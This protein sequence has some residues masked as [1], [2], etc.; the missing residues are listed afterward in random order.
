MQ[1]SRLIRIKFSQW[2]RYLLEVLLVIP[3][4]CYRY[5]VHLIFSER[6]YQQQKLPSLIIILIPCYYVLS[7]YGKIKNITTFNSSKVKFKVL[8]LSSRQNMVEFVEN[9]KVELSNE[10]KPV[11]R[12]LKSQQRLMM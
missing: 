2:R 7:R 10:Y 9:R 6:T 11:G 5:T 8:I 3:H 12:M 4:L 1:P